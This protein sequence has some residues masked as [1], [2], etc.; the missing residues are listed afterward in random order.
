MDVA[1]SCK[2]P[3][4]AIQQI[5][6]TIGTQD[7]T[8][9]NGTYHTFTFYSPLVCLGESPPPCHVSIIISALLLAPTALCLKSPDSPAVIA[10]MC[11]SVNM[12][13][14]LVRS[15]AGSWPLLAGMCGL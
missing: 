12:S 13:L 11:V 9:L 7:F 10:E 2:V 4:A 5:C 14:A 15:G 6:F 1:L 8:H 3:G